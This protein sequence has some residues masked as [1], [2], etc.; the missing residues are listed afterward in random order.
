[1]MQGVKKTEISALVSPCTSAF[2]ILDSSY[3]LCLASKFSTATG[4][5]KKVFA[6]S[7]MYH[8][9]FTFI[10]TQ[11]KCHR[12]IIPLAALALLIFDL[13]WKWIPGTLLPDE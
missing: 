3:P 9:A 6:F 8:M 7:S 2:Q 1:M 11:Q 10:K 4:K 5:K 12:G 13:C